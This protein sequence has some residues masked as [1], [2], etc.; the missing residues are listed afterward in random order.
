MVFSGA[1]GQIDVWLR[2]TAGA[3]LFSTVA[4]ST[5]VLNDVSDVE[6]DR[7]HPR[8]RHRPIASEQV[9]IPIAVVAAVSLYVLSG[10][11]SWLLDPIFL[12]L[13]LLYVGQNVL[14]SLH[15][16]QYLFVDLFSISAGFVIRAVAGVV[17]VGSP[18]SPWLLLCTFLTALMLG[19][20]KR[21][22]EL[23]ETA[24]PTAVRETFEGYSTPMLQ[25]L[26]GSVATTLLMSYSMYTFFAR[27]LAMMLTIP[28][29]FFA[30]FRFVHNTFRHEGSSEPHMLLLDRPLLTN[31]LAWGAVA[32]AVLYWPVSEVFL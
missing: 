32:L 31:F 28:F 21:W 11:L 1:A 27:S 6:A 8:K 22:G 15:L 19:V 7:R 16:K 30:V 4:G 18:L 25:F 20:S 10:V 2:V 24:E 23:T 26:L 13:L 12:G 17:L 5:Y 9:S 14:Y 3:L 29:A